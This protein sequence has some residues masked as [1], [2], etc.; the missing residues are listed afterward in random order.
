MA[1]VSTYLNFNGQTEEA[2]N[3]YRKIFNTELIGPIMRW[4]EMP[5]QPGQ[6]SAPASLANKVMHMEVAIYAGHVLMGTDS[7]E[8][9]GF[10][11]VF[12]NNMYIMLEPDTR[13]ETEKFYKA[14]SEGGKIEMELQDTFW[15]GY[16]A[17]LIDK[18]GQKWMLNCSQKK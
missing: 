14:L 10:K 6:P 15:G 16:Y 13:E 1:R 9:L 7:P 17:T 3:T 12:G 8:E 2:F 5:V 11:T 4:K 18:F